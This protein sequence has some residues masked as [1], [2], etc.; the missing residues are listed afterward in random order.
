MNQRSYFDHKTISIIKGIALIF[1]F[2]HHMLTCPHYFI[3]GISYPSLMSFVEHYQNPF[4]LCVPVFAF[5]TG[6]CYYFGKDKSLKYS[7]KKI[8]NLLIVYWTI[9]ILF[10]MIATITGTYAFDWKN[11]IYELLAIRRPVM[12]FCWYVLFYCTAMLLMPFI[13]CYLDQGKAKAVILGIIIPVVACQMIILRFHNEILMEVVDNIQYWF[14]CM[15]TGYVFARYS[16]FA[17]IM[18]PIFKNNHQSIII[19]ILIWI[20]MAFTAFDGRYY[21]SWFTIISVNF[22]GELID[23]PFNMDIFYAPLFVYG[24]SNLISIIPWKKILVIPE[25]IGKYSL[26]MWLLHCIFFNVS[27]EIFQPI[28][29]LPR[30]PVLVICWGLMLCYFAARIIDIPTKYIICKIDIF[31]FNR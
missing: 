13:R 5:V 3:D 24:I 31:L 25:E 27:K 7:L 8:T 21:A 30:N 9:Y 22:R 14:P 15:V 17:E 1:M 2:I 10:L 12:I 11:V 6:Y 20:T 19:K 4:K 26:H 18:D 23:I 16:V 29:Y 28:L